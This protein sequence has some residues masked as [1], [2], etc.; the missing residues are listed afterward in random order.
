LDL[1]NF[2]ERVSEPLPAIFNSTNRSAV[3]L[4]ADLAVVGLKDGQVELWR[5]QPLEKL[6]NVAPS[7]IAAT[8]LGLSESG[9]WLAVARGDQ[10]TEL[11]DIQEDLLMD[12]LPPL[13][14]AVSSDWRYDGLTFWAGDRRLVRAT[15]GSQRSPALIE[16]FLIP[17]RERR[18]IRHTHKGSLITFAVSPDGTLLATSGLDGRV[19]IWDV[20]SGRELDT[21]HGQLI[22]F[23]SLAFS[24][25]GSRL[26][27]GAWDGTITLWDVETRQQMATWS[28]HR[29]KCD[30][31]SFLDKGRLLA[32]AGE[33]NEGGGE[34]RI[35][36][37]PSWDEIAATEAEA[38]KS[39]H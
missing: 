5:T 24:P 37:A 35:W 3:A 34:I 14:R 12:K 38:K 25:D 1:L 4:S 11:W 20:R 31:L 21:L 19:K 23:F 2:E 32:S 26:A 10:T 16:I 28:A 15:V 7:A 6:R 39:E 13:A 9:R 22:G 29:R 18:L 33:P 27:A 8:E 17:E 36:R 30:W